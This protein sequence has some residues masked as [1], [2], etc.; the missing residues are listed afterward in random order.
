MKIKLGVIGEENSLIVI[1]KI[2]LEYRNKYEYFPCVYRKEDEICKFIENNQEKVDVWLVFGQLDYQRIM[3]WGKAKKP[4]YCIA[5]RGASFYKVLCEA[6]YKNYKVEEMSIDTIPYD[7]LILGFEEMHINYKNIQYKMSA[8][9]NSIKT[10]INFHKRLFEDGKSNL[11]ITSSWSV[12]LAL[13]KI[14]MPVICVL[15]LR[16]SVRMGLNMILTEF[17]IKALKDNQI[18][19]QVF[20]YDLYGKE[21]SMYSVDDLY[22]REIIVSQKLIAYAKQIQGSLK[23]VGQGRFFIF[24]TRGLLA[25]YTNDF[26]SIPND[27]NLFDIETKLVACGIG[28][29]KSA[30]DAEL[31]AVTALRHSRKNK[32][33]EWFV[34]MDDKKI[35]GPLGAKTQLTYDYYSEKLQALSEKSSVSIATLSKIESAIQKYG[36]NTISAQELAIS[37]QIIPRS[38]RRILQKLVDAGIAKEIGDENPNYRGRPRKVFVIDL[39]EQ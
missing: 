11:A 29:G 9:S 28:M 30:G 24:T 21:D 34:I 38:A 19:V 2:I 5:Y 7:E 18:A 1:N 25:A 36:R 23:I 27:N 8:S 33:G 10:Y 6:L 39:N 35:V 37:L 31:N 17:Q 4:V 22:S 32:S 13:E 14:N 3:S 15:P 12:K 26:K 16:V 20:D